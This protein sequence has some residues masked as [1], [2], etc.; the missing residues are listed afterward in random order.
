MS[1]GEKVKKEEK[2]EKTAVVTF[3][4]TG[5][6]VDQIDFHADME[7]VAKEFNFIIT[8]GNV[9]IYYTKKKE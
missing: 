9:N 8:H 7:T 1:F 3:H 6:G 5:E 4:I 2:I